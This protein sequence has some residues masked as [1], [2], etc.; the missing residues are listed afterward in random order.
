M[1]FVQDAAGR[2]L[3]QLA[4]AAP[5]VRGL[6][7]GLSAAEA[8]GVREAAMFCPPEAITVWDDETGEQLFP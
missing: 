8:D 1:H 2:A 3:V 7:D 4:S 5:D 6:L